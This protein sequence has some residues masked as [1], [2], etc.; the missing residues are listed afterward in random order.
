MKLK[1]YVKA[2]FG[3]AIGMCLA[4][5]ANRATCELLNAITRGMSY[6]PESEKETKTET[7]E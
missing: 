1:D 5:L 2:G 3:V 6:K 7:E 4:T